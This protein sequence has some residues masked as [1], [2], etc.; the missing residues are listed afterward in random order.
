MSEKAEHPS[1]KR[2]RERPLAAVNQSV[3]LDAFSL[4]TFVNREGAER[5]DQSGHVGAAFLAIPVFTLGIGPIRSAR[6]Q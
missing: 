3:I 6:R 2:F 5:L 4:C 1:I